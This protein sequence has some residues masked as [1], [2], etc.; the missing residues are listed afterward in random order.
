MRQKIALFLA[1]TMLATP[2]AEL[3]AQTTAEAPQ[4]T[5]TPQIT[6][7][8]QTTTTITKSQTIPQEFTTSVTI[9]SQWGEYYNATVAITNTGD[10]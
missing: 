5:T 10:Q 6:P 8:A 4:V 9:D 7:E 1:L 3:K 2:M